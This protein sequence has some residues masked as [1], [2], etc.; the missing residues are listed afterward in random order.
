MHKNLRTICLSQASMV[1]QSKYTFFGLIFISS[2]PNNKLYPSSW[3]YFLSTQASRYG[4]KP[5]YINNRNI[6]TIGDE[7]LKYVFNN[8]I[9]QEAVWRSGLHVWLVMWKSWVRAPSKAPN[10]FFE[11][12]TLPVLLSWFQER[13]RAWYHNRTKINLGPYGWLA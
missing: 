9:Y 3:L 11:Q 4:P 13:I 5:F 10:C 8:L 12:E 2:L 1:E 7:K 6:H